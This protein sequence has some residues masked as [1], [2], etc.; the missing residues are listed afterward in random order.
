MGDFGLRK[1]LSTRRIEFIVNPR[2][3]G[4]IGDPLIVPKIFGQLHFRHL[5]G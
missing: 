1:A 2:E 3:L 5:G 4:R